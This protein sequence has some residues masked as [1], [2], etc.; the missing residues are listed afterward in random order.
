MGTVFGTIGSKVERERADAVEAITKSSAIPCEENHGW[1]RPMMADNHITPGT[2]RMKSAGRRWERWDVPN[3]RRSTSPFR[4]PRSIDCKAL[5][6][7]SLGFE[8]KGAGEHGGSTA[9]KKAAAGTAS[10]L[11][12]RAMTRN[13]ICVRGP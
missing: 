1:Y 3:R 7:S 13:A 4:V 8:E 12:G 5:A 2:V 10:L 6:P 9:A 11:T